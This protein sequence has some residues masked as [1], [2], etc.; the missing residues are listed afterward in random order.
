MAQ[1][2]SSKIVIPPAVEKKYDFDGEIA[3]GKYGVVFRAASKKTKEQVAVKVML[4]KGNKKD[5]VEREVNVLKKLNHPSILGFHDYHEC[6]AEFV[7]VMEMLH[8]G[9]L[10]DY[11]TQKDFL[12]EGEATHYMKQI[13]EGVAYA[14]SKS[15][16]HLDLKPENIVL[17]DKSAEQLKIIDFGTAQDLS[18]NPRPTVMVGTPEFIAPEVLNLEPCTPA[19]DMWAIGVVAYVLLTGMSPFLGDTDMETIQNIS[20][21]EYEFPDPCPEDGYED[22]TDLAKQFINSVLAQQPK[23]RL[24]A[25]DCLTHA[26]ITTMTAEASPKIS[27][28][29][30]RAF[31]ARRKWMATLRAV[32]VSMSLLRGLRSLKG[33]ANGHGGS[34]GSAEDDQTCPEVFDD[35]SKK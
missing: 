34:N 15:I 28:A 12:N 25:S 2:T 30:L 29:R 1:P 14:H 24:S 23:K 32:R 18:I 16:V 5:D 17:K 10:F 26:W 22:I 4:K 31:R 33:A 6:G 13:L 9:E 11:L 27:T 20:E 21:G 35:N 8:G 19:A 3:R 7:L